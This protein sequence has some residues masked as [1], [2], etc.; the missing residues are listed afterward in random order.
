MYTPPELPSTHDQ[1]PI[2]YHHPPTSSQDPDAEALSNP[3]TPAVE[4]ARIAAT[5]PDAPSTEHSPSSQAEP[6]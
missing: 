2:I 4:L 3:H 5:R 6:P 1:H